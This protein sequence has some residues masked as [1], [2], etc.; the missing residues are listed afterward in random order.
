MKKRRNDDLRPEYDLTQ[1][2]GSVRVSTTSR[3]PR[4][5][6][7]FCWSQTWL[8]PFRTAAR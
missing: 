5:R 1:L 2:K 4:G 7:S 6:I 8:K 3:Q